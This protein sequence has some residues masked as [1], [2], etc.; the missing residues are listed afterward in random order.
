[1]SVVAIELVVAAQVQCVSH[2][3]AAGPELST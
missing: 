2:L 1:V 3:V